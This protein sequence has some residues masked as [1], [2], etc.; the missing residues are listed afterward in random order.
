MKR[1]LFLACLILPVY[2]FSVLAANNGNPYFVDVHLIEISQ[3]LLLAAKTREPADSLVSVLHNL[4][5][6]ELKKQLVTDVEKKAFWINVYNSFTQIFLSKNPDQYK[7]RS[8]FFGRRQIIIAGQN[9]SLDDI[10]HGILRHS[11]VKWSLGYFNKLFPSAFEKENRVDILDYRIHFSLNCGAKS[12]PPIAFYKPE[13]LD[14]QLDMA[15]KVYLKGESEYKEEENRVCVP[16][17][18]G[19]F[20]R[21]FGGKTGMKAL[22]TAFSIIPPGKDPSIKFKKYDWNLYLEN[23]KNE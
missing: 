9:L 15:T 5:V 22:L 3:A 20:R 17:L 18:M 2:P 12:C 11:K 1:M 8:R 10:E 4:P 13:Q 16:A 21:D 7:R 23:Y 14:K 19:W 6:S